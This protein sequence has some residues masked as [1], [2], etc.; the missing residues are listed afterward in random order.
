MSERIN[1]FTFMF[2]IEKK[3]Q[4]NVNRTSQFPLSN[5]GPLTGVPH[6]THTLHENLINP[7]SM[8]VTRNLYKELPT[9]IS[10]FLV[11]YSAEGK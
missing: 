3:D 1:G 4:Q 9:R 7:V 11:N 10:H 5:S 8:S 6:S 2:Y